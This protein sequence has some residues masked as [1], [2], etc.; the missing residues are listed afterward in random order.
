MLNLYKFSL[1][2]FLLSA[3]NK[4]LIIYKPIINYNSNYV[5]KIPK[6]SKKVALIIGQ[7]YYFRYCQG[8]VFYFYKYGDNIDISYFNAKLMLF[9]AVHCNNYNFDAMNMCF[10]CEKRAIPSMRLKNACKEYNAPY[11]EL[12]AIGRASDGLDTLFLEKKQNIKH[13]PAPRL[14]SK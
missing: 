8:V 7:A 14:L 11:W 12:V 10:T 5:Q 4:S 13:N 2:L 3:C 6:H 9:S 1:L